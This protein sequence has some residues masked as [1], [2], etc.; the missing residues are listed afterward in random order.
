MGLL[1]ITEL[2]ETL[3][4]AAKGA[5]DEESTETIGEVDR[6]IG[7]GGRCKWASLEDPEVEVPLPNVR[8]GPPSAVS[9]TRALLGA[10]ERVS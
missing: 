6:A 8:V 4:I 7:G 3:G 10:E 9:L 1:S 5:C 2:K